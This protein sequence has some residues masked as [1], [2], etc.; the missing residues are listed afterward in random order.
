MTQ[1]RN[2]VTIYTDGSSRGNPGPG[3]YGVV[4]KTPEY[5]KELSGGFRKTTNNRMELMGVIE[6]LKALKRPCKVRIYSDSKYIVDA[7][8]QGWAR[9]WKANNWKRNKKEKALNP[10]LW[11][12]LLNLLDTHDVEFVWVKGHANNTEN[13]RCDRL[14]VAAGRKP[15]LPADT[16]YENQDQEPKTPRLF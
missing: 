11:K 8:N 2:K 3:G 13:N 14:A 10:D 6:G 1:N 16:A 15:N 4:L 9:R 7:V 5:R 12:Q